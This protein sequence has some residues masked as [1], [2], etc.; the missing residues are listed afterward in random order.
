MKTH[1]TAL[2]AALSLGLPAAAQ[3]ADGMTES[4]MKHGSTSHDAMKADAMGAASKTYM[5]AMD[6]MNEQTANVTMTGRPG[7]DFAAMMIPHH[8]AAIAMARGYMASGED[9]PEL[10]A[11]SREIIAA[12]EREIAV[13]KDWLARHRQ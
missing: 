8:Q 11:M 4:G 5:D 1:M 3:A 10:T 9:D 6:H 13:L 12:Q 7:A 2:A